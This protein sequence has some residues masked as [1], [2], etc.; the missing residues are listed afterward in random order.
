[1]LWSHPKIKMNANPY[2]L[3]EKITQQCYYQLHS[4]SHLYWAYDI[5]H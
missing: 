1:M 5:I 4:L 2:S 3:V